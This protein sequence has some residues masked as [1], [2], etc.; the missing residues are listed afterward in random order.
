VQPSALEDLVDRVAGPVHRDP[1]QVQVR[2]GHRAYRRPVVPVVAGA[3]QVGGEHRHGHDPAER[4]AMRGGQHLLG[5]G[6]HQHRLAEHRQVGS[7]VG[8]LVRLPDEFGHGRG[9]SADQERG[10]VESLPAGQVVA[11]RYRNLGV[12]PDW[13]IG[14][15]HA[16]TVRRRLGLGL[17]RSLRGQPPGRPF[18][19][20]RVAPGRTGRRRG[21]PRPLCRSRLPVAHP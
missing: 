7:A 8:V 16:D 17:V 1:D 14:Y 20:H 21:A 9:Q 12:E 15:L 11:Q 10:H 5:R 18:R 4:S 3:Q 13:L 2:A 6:E 19:G